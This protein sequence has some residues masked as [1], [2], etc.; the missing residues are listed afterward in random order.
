MAP[1]SAAGRD[2]VRGDEGPDQGGR[3]L[4]PDARRRLALLVGVQARRPISHLVPAPGRRR[5]RADHLR[6]GGRGRRQ[7]I[8]PPRRAR[9]SA[10]T[11]V[12]PR[13]MV[14]D[15]G[16]ER[17]KLRIRDLATGEDIETVTRGRHRRSGLDQRQPGHR[18]HRGQRELAQ[19]PRPLSPPRHAR[20]RR[21][22][23][24]TRRPRTPGFTVGVSRSQD[25]SLIFI[26]TG[27]NAT[28]EIRFVPADDPGRRRP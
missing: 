28:S 20:S 26:S 8:F 17:F 6:R 10:R 23:P 27:D 11:G 1:H 4:G 3:I 9:R 5:R 25:R 12:S 15:D 2:P 24:S 14:D 19:L 22:S 13:A 7:G 16:S 21:T 18:L